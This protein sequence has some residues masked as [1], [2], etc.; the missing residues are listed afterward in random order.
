MGTTTIELNTP[1]MKFAAGHF[2]IF[3]A[4]KRERLHGHN[5]QVGVSIDV[6]EPEDGL[7]FDY[8][9]YKKQI[10]HLC[11]S[12]HEYFLLPGKSPYGKIERNDDQLFFIFNGERIPF[13]ARDVLVLPVPNITVESLASWFLGQL[14]C[15]PEQFVQHKIQS[16]TA[17]VCSGPGQWAVSRWTPNE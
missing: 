3:S 9:I 1:Q 14:R 12:L 5:F 15:E 4:T 13:L 16:M 17:R 2:T 7:V 8:G 10:Y 11:R 6:P